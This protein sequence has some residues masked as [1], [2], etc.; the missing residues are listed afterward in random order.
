SSV[1]KGTQGIGETPRQFPPLLFTVGHNL[2]PA[3]GNVKFNGTAEPILT[4]FNEGEANSPA[5]PVNEATLLSVVTAAALG[6]NAITQQ[7]VV[8]WPLP[9]S[10]SKVGKGALYEAKM[11]VSKAVLGQSTACFPM[12]AGPPTPFGK[13]FL[14]ML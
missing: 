9:F 14:S 2:S 1:P 12:Y 13:L 4:R 8:P 11:L 7:E 5:N 10:G 6:S 3:V